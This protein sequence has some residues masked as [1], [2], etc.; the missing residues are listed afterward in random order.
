M[1]NPANLPDGFVAV[2]V[3]GEIRNLRQTIGALRQNY[4][5]AVTL[6]HGHTE[7]PADLRGDLLADGYELLDEPL[8][9]DVLVSQMLSANVVHY[10]G[11]GVFRPNPDG[12]G[13]VA[14][15]YL[16]NTPDGGLNVVRDDELLPRL[17]GAAKLPHLVVLMACEGAR[18][19][20]VQPFAGLAGKLVEAGVPA[21][22]AMQTKLPIEDAT[23]LTKRFYAD[24]LD[25]GTVDLAAN[26]ARSYLYGAH[27][28]DYSIPALFMRLRDG[29]LLAPDPALAALKAIIA[30]TDAAA[31]KPTLPIDVVLTTGLP[32]SR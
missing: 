9:L 32:Y 2:D 29:Q 15:L 13:G 22:F 17:N 12:A 23:E 24:L 28:S 19:A 6:A 11:H 4:Q 25:N 5:L 10:L 27:K 1:S 16:E 26:A 21:V 20:G 31:K 3:V 18:R 7:L 30:Q 8:T 14:A